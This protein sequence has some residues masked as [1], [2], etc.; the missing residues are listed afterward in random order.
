MSTDEVCSHNKYG[1]CKHGDRCWKKHINEICQ[2]K[3]CQGGNECSKRHPRKCKFFRDYQRCKFG[4]YCAFDHSEPIDAA[5]EEL[6]L[7][8]QKLDDLEKTIEVKNAEIK[9]ILV[10]LDGIETNMADL[11]NEHSKLKIKLSSS[12]QTPR[13]S[14]VSV[15]STN[16]S[17]NTMNEENFIPQLDGCQSMQMHICEN[18]ETTFETDEQLEKHM[19]EHEWGCDDCKLCCTSK[20]FVD[21]HE[22]EHHGDTPDSIRYIRDDI[23]ESTKKLFA[24]GHRFKSNFTL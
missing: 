16:N 3:S 9:A 19:Q 20:Y 7:L 23:P 13:P 12:C 2:S 1:F 11:N 10:K 8:K 6:K 14:S 4:E 17:L 21:L 15:I 18:C 5:E 24:A 22:L